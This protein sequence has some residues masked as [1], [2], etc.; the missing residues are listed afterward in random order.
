MKKLLHVVYLFAAMISVNQPCWIVVNQP[1]I[2]ESLLA[3]DR[4]N[5]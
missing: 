1:E 2:P 5:S 3:Y 4:L